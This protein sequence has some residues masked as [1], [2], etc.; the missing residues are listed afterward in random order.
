MNTLKQLARILLILPVISGL[1]YG[2]AAG[3]N[4]KLSI[5]S[6][7][8]STVRILTGDFEDGLFR[9]QTS[10]AGVIIT[11]SGAVLTS[12]QAI[13]AP[14][15]Q[16][17][18][19]L[20]AL[21]NESSDSISLN[22][23]VRLKVIAVNAE[24]DLALLQLS[25]RP[26]RESAVPYVK[27]A[28]DEQIE[29]G[30]RVSLH[31]FS[32]TSGSTVVRRY[33]TILDF[34]ERHTRA[35]WIIVDG[36]IDPQ[37]TGGPVFDEKGRLIGIQTLVRQSRQVPFFG[38]DDFPIGLA[39]VGEI[40][41]VRSLGSLIGFLLEPTNAQLQLIPPVRTVSVQVTGRVRDAKTGEPV[42]GAVIGIILSTKMD[43]TSLIT[44]RELVGYGRSSFQ[45]QFEISRRVPPAR[46]LVK[47]VHPQYQTIVKEVTIG[48]G[49]PELSIEMAR[50][51]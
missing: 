13:L 7:V 45:G 26:G 20:W 29:Y 19:V 23:A 50:N 48:P 28:V 8:S 44:A 1:G 16:T 38:D 37:S 40:G 14:D 42:P 41:Y 39:N 35:N 11:A 22:R 31:G 9:G 3:G 32:Q 30:A 18:P 24:L 46:Y 12:R 25:F 51:Q 47:V 36:R 21:M 2:L 15:G 33:S 27:F 43:R 4:V 34:D 6:S 10:G 49:E 5:Q 17:A